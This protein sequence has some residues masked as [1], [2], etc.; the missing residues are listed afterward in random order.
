MSGQG[1][2]RPLHTLTTGRYF[3]GPRWRD[4]F[5][6]LVDSLARTVLRIDSAGHC[7]TLWEV[8]DVPAGMGFLP[9]G[10]TVVTAMFQRSLLRYSGGRVTT[11]ADL[12]NVARGTIDDMVIDGEGRSFVGDLGFDLRQNVPAAATGGLVLVT[13]E[14]VARIGATG[15]HFPNGI[16]VSADNCNL[17][18][19]ESNGDCLSQFEIGSDGSLTFRRR[20]AHIGEPDGICL[21]REGGVW[22][23]AFKEDSVVRVDREGHMTDRI[24]LPG[25]GIACALGGADRRSLFCISAQTTHEGL[26]RGE[27]T[28]RVDMVR[29]AI[30]GAGHP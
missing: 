19:A 3:E 30:P 27:S 5:L 14:G 15:L 29:V 28:S 11:Y 10:E 8:P 12:S 25:R 4:G 24:A 2:N 1:G 26:A 13:A 16:A 17:I 18:V 7:E 21:D 20:F 23:G 6:W 22:V 9:T